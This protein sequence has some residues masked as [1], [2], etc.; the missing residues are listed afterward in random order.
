MDNVRISRNNG[1]NYRKLATAFVPKTLFE[2][3]VARRGK[4]GRE[5]TAVFSRLTQENDRSPKAPRCLS[6]WKRWKEYTY[7]S[8]LRGEKSG[9]GD[10]GN[11]SRKYRSRVAALWLI[12]FF[13]DVIFVYWNGAIYSYVKSSSFELF[14]YSWKIVTRKEQFF[15]FYELN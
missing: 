10:G 11:G 1:A 5:G 13:N 15:F 8:F 12:G 14:I 9:N 4:R 2:K 3:A 6:R 7:R